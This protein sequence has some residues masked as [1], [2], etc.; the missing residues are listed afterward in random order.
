MRIGFTYEETLD[1]PLG[2]L[3]TLIAIEQIKNE[4]RK[5]KRS[6]EDEFFDLLNYR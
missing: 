1:L 5:E 3:K 6:E 4:G 2:D